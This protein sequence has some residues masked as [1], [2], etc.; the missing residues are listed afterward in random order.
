MFCCAFHK[1]A[2]FQSYFIDLNGLLWIGLSKNEMTFCKSQPNTRLIWYNLLLCKKHSKTEV[3]FGTTFCFVKSM[4]K[5]RLDL[6]QPFSKVV[7]YNLLL[8]KKHS[9]T[10]VGFGTTFLKGCLAQPFSKVVWNGICSRVH[11]I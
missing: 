7:W 3:G 4:A 8:C 9:K 2:L 10:E 5:I 11:P 6:V 1:K